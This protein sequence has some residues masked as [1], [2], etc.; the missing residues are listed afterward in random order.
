MTSVAPRPPMNTERA[1]KWA[2]FL[3]ATAFV[4]YLCLLILGPFVNILA[5]S[6]VLAIA[7][8]PVHERL[9]RKTGRPALSALL[10]SALVVV[11]ILIPLLF[12]TGLAVNQFLA[13]RDYILQTSS[14]EGLAFVEPV[15]RIDDWLEARVGIDTTAIIGWVRQHA[16]ELA[17][18]SAEYSLAIAANVTTVVMSFVFTIFAM[19]LLFRDGPRIVARIPDLLPFD[20]ARSEALLLRIRD[21]IYGGVY[22]VV[23]IALIQGTLTGLIFWIL[24]I[25]SAALWGLV[26]VLTSVIP[27]FGAAA[28]WVPGAIYLA[29][30]GRWVQMIV[31]TVF[32]TAVISGIDN[33]LRP[34]LVG[35]RVGLNELVMFFAILGGLQA[36]GVLGIVLGPVVF[37][38][39]ASIVDVLSDNERT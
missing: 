16:N 3:G 21:V 17:R 38:I 37:A 31:L 33:F 24:G 30:T 32:G 10:V 15:R 4:V 2:I 39:A 29:A 19:F 22:G 20:N 36:F 6:A 7:F 1:L 14:G 25:P 26:T 28:V 5:W 18:V 12:L 27:M 23:V 8:H 34:R 13:L 35:G 11:A 9:V